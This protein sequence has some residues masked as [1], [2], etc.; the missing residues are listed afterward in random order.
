[1][2][3]KKILKCR[4]S[5]QNYYNIP[6]LLW[7]DCAALSTLFIGLESPLGFVF[8]LEAPLKKKIRIGTS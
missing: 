1:M 4:F 2:Y 3:K 7:A 8:G 5:H 6:S